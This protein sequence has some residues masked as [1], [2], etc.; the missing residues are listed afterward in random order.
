MSESFRLTRDGWLLFIARAV[1][2]FAYGMISIILLLYLTATG[3]SGTESGLLLS[4]TLIGD[5]FISLYLSLQADRFGRRRTLIVGAILMLLAGLVF[6]ASTDFLILLTAAT[7]GVISPS[8]TEVGPFLSVEQAALS[9][10]AA[11]EQRT[12]IFAWYHLVGICS[13]AVGAA[14]AGVVT[15]W[16]RTAGWSDVGVYRPVLWIYSGCGLLLAI[17]AWALRP[18]IETR[19]LPEAT[20]IR[21]RFGLHR[22]GPM[23]AQLCVLFAID[24][25]GGG[26]ILQTITAYWFV[27]KFGV[28]DAELGTI[29]LAA[30]LLAGASALIAGRLA[31]RFGLINTMVFT[32]LPSNILLMLLPL[33]P[34][35]TSAVILL[36]VRYSISQM[37]VPTRQAFTMEV[38]AP[39]ERSAAAAVTSVTRSIGASGSP[40]LATTLMAQPGW[41][42]APFLLAGG[43]KIL[44]DIMLFTLFSRHREKPTHETTPGPSR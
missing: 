42:S 33:M 13:S 24:A 5:T 27:E 40:A 31:L 11:A 41:L 43:I 8:G 14:V 4:L 19:I 37:D 10:I 28:G 7:L 18:P 39:D 9:E 35:F 1:R 15:A 36:L 44:Y 30:N 29:F 3:L 23:V 38:V 22:S 32:H 17:L 20:T 12:S 21:R 16:A 2:M 6:S 34:D 26:F 25:F